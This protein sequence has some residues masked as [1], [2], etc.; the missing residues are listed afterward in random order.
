MSET[1]NLLQIADSVDGKLA[2][3]NNAILVGESK[4]RLKHETT[5]NNRYIPK[6]DNN[7]DS[8]NNAY[9]YFFIS[10]LISD[11]KTGNTRTRKGGR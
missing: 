5:I 9:H 10:T 11:I 1:K 7:N 8:W 2:W 3:K 6:E 4:H